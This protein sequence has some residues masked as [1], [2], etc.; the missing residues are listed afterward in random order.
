[1]NWE[2][3]ML[4]A[5]GVIGVIQYAKGFLPKAPHWVWAVAQPTLCIALGAAYTY[6]PS[7]II[8]GITAL[9]LSQIGYETIIQTIKKKIDGGK[10]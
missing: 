10:Q 9:A 2:T 6:L 8:Y 3:I 4:V 5:F 7:W 1:M